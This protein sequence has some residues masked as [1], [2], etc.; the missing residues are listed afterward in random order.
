MPKRIPMSAYAFLLF[1]RAVSKEKE[2]DSLETFLK[3]CN[4]E[5]NKN[6]EH[7]W[8]KKIRSDYHSIY[9]KINNEILVEK[10]QSVIINIGENS[11]FFKL[12]LELAE[13]FPN[14]G[15]LS[16]G[17]VDF[18]KYLESYVSI[19][20]TE[21]AV[22]S[23]S[24]VTKGIQNI[25]YYNTEW[26]FYYNEY[27]PDSPYTKISRLYLVISRSGL[28][29]LFDRKGKV[30]FNYETL[31]TAKSG[32]DNLISIIE[33]EYSLK[34]K[35]T[36]RIILPKILEPDTV[37]IGQYMD[38]EKQRGIISGTFVLQKISDALTKKESKP[39]TNPYVKP[40]KEGETQPEY[41]KTASI[42][43]GTSK[44]REVVQVDLA[45]FTGWE[46]YIPIEI[47]QYLMHKW[48]NFT[49]S[50]P[51]INSLSKLSD[52]LTPQATGYN[53]AKYNAIINYD[54]YLISPV[55]S[56]GEEGSA[57]FEKINSAFFSHSALDKYDNNFDFKLYESSDVLKKLNLNK[58]YF[59]QRVIKAQNPENENLTNAGTWLK[60]GYA[61]MKSSRFVILVMPRKLS[62]SA[63]VEVG[64]AIDM[65]KPIFIFESENNSLPNMIS[66]GDNFNIYVA[67]KPIEV[68]KIPDYIKL[69]YADKFLNQ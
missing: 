35:L 39:K 62:C 26:Y 34:R 29:T 60:T 63:L 49:E 61:A 64:W 8:I 24:K 30:K 6:S 55:A 17:I 19:R 25:E 18:C 43:T 42:D 58:T 21:E 5:I 13:K 54:I 31:I 10:R 57:H 67:D 20:T 9:T 15:I 32:G 16:N 56:L 23:N 47:A 59:H 36:L 4:S 28:I 66:Q 51:K 7:K 1:A 2:A 44:F 3:H 46:Q 53:K 38:F 48:K 65:E 33:F 69:N 27:Y 37:L 41:L 68:E 50:T 52:F 40:L 14:N 12:F 22:S 11:I 45:Y